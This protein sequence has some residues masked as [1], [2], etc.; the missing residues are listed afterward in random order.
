VAGEPGQDRDGYDT[1]E[2]KARADALTD[3]GCTVEEDA[4]ISAGRETAS[5]TRAC[6]SAREPT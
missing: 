6:R 1:G 2:G 3:G 5:S 4:I